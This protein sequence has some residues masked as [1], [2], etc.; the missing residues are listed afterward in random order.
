MP[1]WTVVVV[2]RSRTPWP[3]VDGK[4]GKSYRYK[5]GWVAQEAGA[6]MRLLIST[7]RARGC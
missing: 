6:R 1:A 7:V 3:Q 5:P 4:E 2:A